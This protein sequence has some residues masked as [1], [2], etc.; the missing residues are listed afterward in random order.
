M[1]V[2]T[3]PFAALLAFVDSIQDD[4]RDLEG[5]FDTPLVM[6]GLSC[7]PNGE[8]VAEVDVAALDSQSILEKIIEGRDVHACIAPHE[9]G[10]I[11]RYPSWMIV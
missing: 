2:H 1:P 11:L 10:L 5:I 9:N 4:R 8:I 3:L 7:S 6:T